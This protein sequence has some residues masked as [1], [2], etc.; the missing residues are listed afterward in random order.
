MSASARSA[1]RFWSCTAL[2]RV[3]PIAYGEKLYALARE[4]KKFVRFVRGGHEDL[5]DY[6]AVEAARE[7]L[8][9]V[10]SK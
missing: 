8:G 4:P 9:T 5:N 10:F 2:D 1:P 7:F 3:V 6:G